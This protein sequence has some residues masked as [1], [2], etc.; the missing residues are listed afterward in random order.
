MSNPNYPG[1][2][3]EGFVSV[4]CEKSGKR[5]PKRCLEVIIDA[6]P[7][8]ELGINDEWVIISLDEAERLGKHLLEVVAKKRTPI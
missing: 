3:I 5:D 4:D 2:S 7:N 1:Y 8:I 6:E